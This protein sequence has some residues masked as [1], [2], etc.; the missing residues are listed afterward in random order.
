MGTGGQLIHHDSSE[1]E[2]SLAVDLKSDRNRDRTSTSTSSSAASA[3]KDT[4]EHPDVKPRVKRRHYYEPAVEEDDMSGA[5]NSTN[6]SG[7]YMAT[8]DEKEKEST[9]S[10]EPPDMIKDELIAFYKAIQVQGYV[11]LE[12]CEDIGPEILTKISNDMKSPYFK[13][14]QKFKAHIDNICGSITLYADSGKVCTLGVIFGMATHLKML[15]VEPYMRRRGAG[16]LLVK[17]YENEVKMRARHRISSKAAQVIQVNALR[18]DHFNSK[19]F[20][21]RCGFQFL[22]S[23]DREGFKEILM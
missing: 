6:T 5:V 23:A 13:N 7:F 21:V 1:K 9:S 10:S 4:T 20:W 18:N 17:W 16:K 12:G 22:N 8:G 14:L 15:W 19:D 11:I 2:I 3:S